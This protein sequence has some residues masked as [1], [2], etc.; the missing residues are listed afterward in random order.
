MDNHKSK[1]HVEISQPYASGVGTAVK[2][3]GEEI[4]LVTK[5]NYNICAGEIPEVELT[6]AGTGT[7]NLNCDYVKVD[8]SPTNLKDAVIILRDELL[9][10]NYLYD[11]FLAS[12]KSAVA[13]QLCKPEGTNDDELAEAVLKRIIG[14]A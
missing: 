7:L 1:C 13:E 9:K 6:I 12:I 2:L 4:P 5:V 11:S 3:N 14:E 8:I 10:H